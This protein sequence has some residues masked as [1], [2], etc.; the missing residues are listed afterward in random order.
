ME[1]LRAHQAIVYGPGEPYAARVSGRC[2][3]KQRRPRSLWTAILRCPAQQAATIAREWFGLRG[4]DADS[5]VWDC[6]MW[7]AQRTDRVLVSRDARGRIVRWS[8]WL[9]P[10]GKHRFEVWP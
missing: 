10:A 5:L 2:L 3:D 4:A 1:R 6:V 7:D 9:D 8:V